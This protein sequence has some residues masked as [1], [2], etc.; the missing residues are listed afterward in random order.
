[1]SQEKAEALDGLA[2]SLE[3]IENSYASLIEK[4][5]RIQLEL[6]EHDLNDEIEKLSEPMSHLSNDH[7]AV[8]MLHADL[9]MAA[10][11]ERLEDE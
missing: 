1:M 10:N 7:E 2:S 8:K 5:G 6:D 4:M 9:Q 3:D 11:Q